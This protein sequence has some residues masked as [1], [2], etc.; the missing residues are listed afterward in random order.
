MIKLLPLSDGCDCL[1]LL[2]YAGSNRPTFENLLRV[3]R[4]GAIV[5]VAQLPDSNDAYVDVYSSETGIEASTWSG[6]RVRID[7]TTGRMVERHFTK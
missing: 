4:S 6:F 7:I 5:W 2:D 1:V 3:D